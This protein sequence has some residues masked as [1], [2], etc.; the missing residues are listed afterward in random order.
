MKDAIICILLLKLLILI[1][2]ICVSLMSGCTISMQNISSIG[3]KDDIIDDLK[4]DN[5]IETALKV[6]AI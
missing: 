4:P 5:E 1:A 3:S 2:I 6:P